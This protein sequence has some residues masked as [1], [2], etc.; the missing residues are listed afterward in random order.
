MD[1]PTFWI[2]RESHE[3]LAHRIGASYDR[4]KA[5]NIKLMG[6]SDETSKSS[7]L[8]VESTGLSLGYDGPLFSGVNFQL[9]EGERLE[10]RG[11]NGA[12]KSTF[13]K[14]LLAYR[15]GKKPET[16]IAGSIAVDPHVTIGL[17]EQEI[18]DDY[19]DLTLYDA[20]ERTYLDRRL[21]VNDQK[22]RQLL[23]SYLFEPSDGGV[24]VAQL[25]G[26]QKARLQLIAMLA[27]EP[28]LLILDEPTNHLDLPSI[29]ELEVALDGYAGAV[30]FVSHDDYFRKKLGAGVVMIGDK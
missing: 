3:G 11:R 29:E 1:K 19:F 5:Q 16:H 17:Y 27:N 12:G 28:Q 14:A 26:G 20:I 21:P 23:H 6:L 13:I 22:V 18:R 2:D 25:S 10:L 8:L 4:H 24:I 7:H 9:R 30:L 15:A